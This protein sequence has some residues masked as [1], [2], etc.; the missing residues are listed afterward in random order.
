MKKHKN[1]I[2]F[3]ALLAALLAFAFWWGG[4]TPGARG[5]KPAPLE[6]ET[7]AET[8]VP[9]PSD[10]PSLQTATPAVPKAERETAAPTAPTVLP[11]PTAVPEKAPS[12]APMEDTTAPSDETLTCTLSV[13][14][15]TLLQNAAWLSEEKAALVPPDGVILPETEVVFFAGESVFNVL[16]RELK[17]HKIHLEF[18]NTPLYGSA[19]IE[20]IHN[21]YEFDCGEMSGWMYRVNGV[22]PN[23]GCSRY[24]VNCGD[25]IEWVYTCD[26][27]A[28]VGGA[29]A[30]RN[31][32]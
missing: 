9:S 28:D 8:P 20:G 17:R 16:V 11:V 18:V 6:T 10:A 32:A 1:K 19:Y 22:F 26:L 12:A 25:R 15:D 5:W 27:G 3:G 30:A 14:C 29:Y 13:R 2:I 24:T 23:Y 7:A 21:L 4:N 31:G